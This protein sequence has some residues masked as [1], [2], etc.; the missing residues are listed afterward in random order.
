[1]AYKPWDDIDVADDFVLPEGNPVRG[2][3]LFKKHCA[4]C[5]AIRRDGMNPYGALNGPNLCGIMGRTAAQNQRTGWAAYSAALKASGILW[6]DRN[7]MAFLKNPRVFAGGVVNMNFRGMESV[8]DRVDLIHYLKKAGHEEW[9]VRDGSPHTQKG[10]WERGG[11]GGKSY[12]EVHMSQQQLKPWQHLY[13][14][15]HQKV[16]AQ[17][18]RL[19]WQPSQETTSGAYS[20]T[21]VVELQDAES[22]RQAWRRIKKV[23][24]GVKSAERQQAFDWPPP[25]VIASGPIRQDTLEDSAVSVTA[26]LAEDGVTTEGYRAPSGIMVYKECGGPLSMQ[27]APRK[28]SPQG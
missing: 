27:A 3:L 14:A 23:A 10:W 22:E 9:M 4:Q 16:M 8:Q 19:G 20:S 21:D 7:M 13:R 17:L 1:M 18:E 26:E 5:H 12:W 15:A 2:Q 24:S 11:A 6:T 28:P 25:Q